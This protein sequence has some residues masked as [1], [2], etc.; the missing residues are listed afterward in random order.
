MEQTATD[1]NVTLN[2]EKLQLTETVACASRLPAKHNHEETFV[3]DMFRSN[4][5]RDK[6]AATYS[7]MLHANHA[8]GGELKPLIN[9]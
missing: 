2:L 4:L 7:A 1:W 5:M 6:L 3:L 9:Q 8:R